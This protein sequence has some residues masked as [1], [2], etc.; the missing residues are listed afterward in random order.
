MKQEKTR[1]LVLAA[2]ILALGIIIPAI[3]HYTGINGRVFLPMHLPVLVGGLVLSPGYALM[4]GIFTPLINSVL[5]GMPPIFPV[6][7]TMAI[8][9]GIYGLMASVL[10]RHFNLP[11]LVSL[12][13]TIFIGRV[14][15]GL[16]NYVF[17]IIFNLDVVSPLTWVAG[18]IATGIPGIIAQIVIVPFV[19][20]AIDRYYSRDLRAN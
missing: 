3:F 10:R 12:I 11:T 2:L 13:I 6:A 5:T 7:I 4:L 16:A 8:E 17:A 18:T 9:L 19:V 14:L 15:A 1:E 20:S